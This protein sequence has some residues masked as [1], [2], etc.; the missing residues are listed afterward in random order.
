MQDLS[1]ALATWR[2]GSLKGPIPSALL[3]RLERAKS[4]KEEKIRESRTLTAESK[5]LELNEVR[6]NFREEWGKLRR[7][8]IAGYEE[9]AA[10]LQRVVN[11]PPTNAELER[12]GLLANVHV[13]S[14]TRAGGNL[15]RAAEEFA[16]QGDRAG[17]RLAKENA[18]LAPTLGARQAL[19][20]GIS[21]AEEGLMSPEQK[22][23]R[24]DLGL[25]EAER[26]NFEAGTA[27]RPI[28][29]MNQ[30]IGPASTQVPMAGPQ[31]QR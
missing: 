5:R 10:Q 3:G 17:L 18:A 27:A 25:L 12:M 28:A 29:K 1:T 16:A 14:W 30:A 23:A 31:P 20:E 24:D 4:A 15:I 26:S 7:D 9:K 6:R 2:A 19:L 11:P 8:I 22:K 21:D 13:A